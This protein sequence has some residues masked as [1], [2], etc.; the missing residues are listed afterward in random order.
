MRNRG[1]LEI[2]LTSFRRRA[3]STLRIHGTTV[4][5]AGRCAHGRLALVLGIHAAF[6]IHGRQMWFFCECNSYRKAVRHILWSLLSRRDNGMDMLLSDFCLALPLCVFSLSQKSG[7]RISMKHLGHL[8]D[9]NRNCGGTEC[10]AFHI[11]CLSNSS[12]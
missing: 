9:W 5:H 12:R 3:S 11:Y 4:Q 1:L 6:C 7:L 10:T 8:W 2:R